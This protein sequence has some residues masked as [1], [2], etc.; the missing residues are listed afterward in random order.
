[1]AG[2]PSSSVQQSTKY[3]E[4]GILNQ[5]YDD[6]YGFLMTEIVGFDAAGA[7]RRIAVNS[8]GVLSAETGAAVLN[9]QKTVAVSSTAVSISA[10]QAVKNG[11]IVQALA[12]NAGNVVVG[13]SSVTTVNG[14]QLQPGQ[15]TSV[16]VS[17]LS[18]VYVNGT[19]GDGVCFIASN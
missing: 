12:G 15:A 1:M 19:A 13:S 14:Y 10:S 16:A 4:Q 8:S 11:V 9:G 7:I 6:T 17:D 5:S 3:S 18:A 2:P